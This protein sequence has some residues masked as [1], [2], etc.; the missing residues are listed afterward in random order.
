VRYLLDT[1]V[2]SETRR[3]RRDPGLEE[4]IAGT[5]LE[6][7]HISVITVGEIGR[8]ITQLFER[9]DPKQGG[10]LEKWLNE[11]VQQFGE[12]I[13]PVD[14]LVA[15]RWADQP[16]SQS[17]ATADALIAATAAANNLTLVTRNTKDFKRTGVRMINPFTN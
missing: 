10:V 13:V 1:N 9:G 12:R 11:V 4:W 16:V 5:Q 6:W 14:V 8:G 15:R 17:L 3:R 2:L 7:L